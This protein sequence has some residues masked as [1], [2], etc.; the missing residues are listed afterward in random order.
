MGSLQR[1]VGGALRDARE[2]LERF[3]LSRQTLRYDEF[4]GMLGLKPWVRLM[5]RAIRDAVRMQS[6][7]VH[8]PWPLYVFVI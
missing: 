8:A 5:P 3:G 7:Q 6:A 1:A 2:A 4:V